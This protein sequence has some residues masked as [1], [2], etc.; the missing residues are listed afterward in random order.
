MKKRILLIGLLIIA[1]LISGSLAASADAPIILKSRKIA[2]TQQIQVEPAL[3]GM[4]NEAQANV[5]SHKILQFDHPISEQERK[6]LENQGV[7]LSDYMP[8]NAWMASYTPSQESV[9]EDYGLKFK[10]ELQS[11]DKLDSGLLELEGNLKVSIKFYD[12][13]SKGSV[14]SVVSKYSGDFGEDIS[15]IITS[16]DSSKLLDIAS[17]DSVQWIDFAGYEKISYL[18]GARAAAWVNQV[19][20]NPYLYNG[21][22]VTIAEWDG[23]WADINHNAFSGRAIVGDSVDQ[24]ALSCRN[25]TGGTS[26]C[27]PDNHA[28]HVGGIIAGNGSASGQYRGMAPNASLITYEW[29]DN[30]SETIAEINH[31]IDAY[32]AIVSSNSWGFGVDNN[33]CSLLGYY[34][35]QSKWFDNLSNWG[36]NGSN[37]ITFVFAA[38]NYRNDNVCDIS[39]NPYNNT[40]G[41]GATAKNPITVGSVNSNDESMTSYSSWGPT[42]DGRIKPEVVAPGDEVG[43]NRIYSTGTGNSYYSTGGT[44]MAAPV[45]SGIVALMHQAYR[46]TH[47][48]ADQRPATDKAILTHTAKDL[49]NTGP[50]YSTGFG[51]VNATQAIAKILEYSNNTDVIIENT[52]S[53]DS[54]TSYT[55]YANNTNDPLKFTLAWDDLPPSNLPAISLVNDLDLLVYAPNGTRYYPWVLNHTVPNTPASQNQSDYLNPIEQI[56]VGDVAVGIWTITVNSSASQIGTQTFSLVTSHDTNYESKSPPAIAT[57]LTNRSMSY[58]WIYWDWI[59]PD[60]PDFNHTEVWINDSFYA[61]V[62]SPTSSYNFTNATINTLYEIQIRTA[63]NYGNINTTWV[64]N[65][66][67]TPQDTTPPEVVLTSPIP[68]FN[69]SSSQVSF[70]CNATDDHDISSITL[71]TNISGTWKANETSNVSGTSAGV[72]FTNMSNISDGN[73]IWNCQVNDS[74]QNN[75][76]FA[77]DRIFVVDLEEANITDVTP[78]RL[79][80]R[81]EIINF[82]TLVTDSHGVGYVELN[83]SGTKYNLTKESSASNYYNYTLDTTN[84]VTKVYDYSIT[85]Y[86]IVRNTNSTA[87]EIEIAEKIYSNTTSSISARTLTK[88]LNHEEVQLSLLLNSTESNVTMSARVYTSDPNSTAGPDGKINVS[89]FYE[90]IPDNTVVSAL[91]YTIVDMYY[92]QDDVAG[93]LNESS[94]KV[95]KLSGGSWSLAYSPTPIVVDTTNN[96]VR[97]N[98]T[99][100]SM[101]GLFGSANVEEEAEDSPSPG[102]GG[103]SGAPNPKEENEEEEEEVE[104]EI[105]VIEEKIEVIELKEKVES[106]SSEIDSIKADDSKK[107]NSDAS[108][109]IEKAENLLQQALSAANNGD[110]ETA[111]NLYNEAQSYIYEARAMLKA[112]S[113]NKVLGF[114]NLAFK[115]SWKAGLVS[116]FLLSCLVFSFQYKKRNIS[117]ANSNSGLT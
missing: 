44:S 112:K 76:S 97:V 98:L 53:A 95:Y 26:L 25:T 19:Q 78:Q 3:R 17:E 90:F 32:S 114:V 56:Y 75:I 12:D 85:A 66:T 47:N 111:N 82:T 109:L 74:S 72:S 59:L 41:P 7:I 55:I 21:S 39:N 61:N 33:Y 51:L 108:Q 31:S 113:Q 24:G 20:A 63:D 6:Q 9:L 27:G 115:K 101:Y 93:N 103:P 5:K 65:T 35:S 49:N 62:S 29:P 54:N 68:T 70:T 102:G 71:F 69:T 28:T 18:D 60:D 67:R 30:E 1:I 104:K 37:Y 15:S 45:V 92:D 11:T 40:A 84:F 100:F 38:G 94:L 36:I 52:L 13:V 10:T 34:H 99:S 46:D 22:G 4:N 106:L 96:Y 23:G 79:V 2:T 116:L 57:N 73:Y 48:N 77:S 88:V 50:D 91:G 86:D 105:E 83:I 16:I 8:G 87:N 43:G 64:N 110:I 107:K 42:D 81:T 89:Q 117:P 14:Q 80:N 58:T